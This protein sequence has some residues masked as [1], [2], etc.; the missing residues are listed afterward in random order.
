MTSRATALHCTARLPLIA[1]VKRAGRSGVTGC[2]TLLA[3]A[4]PIG[5]LMICSTLRFLRMIDQRRWLLSQDSER[6]LPSGSY[7]ESPADDV[8]HA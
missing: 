7:M 2:H 5:F 4:P 6:W 1:S 8:L 3:Y